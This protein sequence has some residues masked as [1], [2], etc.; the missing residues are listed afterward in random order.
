MANSTNKNKN[1]VR[2]RKT[3]KLLTNYIL[4]KGDICCEADIDRNL[5]IED[6][7][8]L[9]SEIADFMFE[10]EN[11]LDYVNNDL[12]VFIGYRMFLE[13]ANNKHG[14]RI[15]DGMMRKMQKDGRMDKTRIT[16]LLHEVPLYY[17][18]AFLGYAQYKH[19][20]NQAIM[21]LNKK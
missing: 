15:W 3:K 18:M 6:I 12:L 13:K 7:F 20:R 17:L 16:E 21:A 19:R 11:Y 8:A 14:V 4:K 9:Y 1:T 5:A 2:G 10:K